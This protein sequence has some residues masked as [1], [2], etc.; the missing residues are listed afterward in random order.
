MCVLY[1]GRE[2][3]E[4]VGEVHGH[5]YSTRYGHICSTAAE[6]VRRR[7]VRYARSSVRTKA[8]SMVS[9]LFFRSPSVYKGNSFSDSGRNTIVVSSLTYRYISVTCRYILVYTR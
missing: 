7:W 4:A 8:A 3:E 5:I 2:G 1:R 9:A 6:R